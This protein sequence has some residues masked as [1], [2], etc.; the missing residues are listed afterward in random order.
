MEY[1]DPS[2]EG[3]LPRAILHIFQR[4]TSHERDT[5]AKGSKCIVSCQFI[6]VRMTK[7]VR[8]DD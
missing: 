6:E 2:N 7:I 5:E 3:I 1:M 4:C 8:F